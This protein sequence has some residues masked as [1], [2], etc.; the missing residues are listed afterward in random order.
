MIYSCLIVFRI[1]N[2]LWVIVYYLQFMIRILKRHENALLKLLFTVREKPLIPG[3]SSNVYA[4][5]MKPTN[6]AFFI[7]AFNHL[8]MLFTTTVAI[9][10]VIFIIGWY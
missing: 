4:S 2:V 9:N 10:L 6:L 8:S 5:E 3:S 7:V 1:R